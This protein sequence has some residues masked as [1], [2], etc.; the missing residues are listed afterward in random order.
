MSPMHVMTNSWSNEP[1]YKYLN[2]SKTSLHKSIE[3]V[4]WNGSSTNGSRVYILA[5][6][7][8]GADA[9]KYFVET[10]SAAV[11]GLMDSK[12]WNLKLENDRTELIQDLTDIF[13]Q[14]DNDYTLLKYDQFSEWFPSYNVMKKPDDDGCTLVLNIIKDGYL[15]NAN[16]GDSRTILGVKQEGETSIVFSS[17]DHN[18]TNPTKVL[19]IIQNGGNFVSQKGQFFNI[20]SDDVNQDFSQL[21]GARIY[22]SPSLL[23]IGIGLSHRRTLNLTGSMGDIHFK[24]EPPVLSSTPDVSIMELNPT[25]EYVMIAATD[26]VWDHLRTAPNSQKQNDVV[27]DLAFAILEGD[28]DDIITDSILP[29]SPETSIDSCER[30]DKAMLEDRLKYAADALVKRENADQSLELFY[31]RMLRY[32]DAT[33]QIIHMAP[34][35]WFLT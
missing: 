8:G 12:S 11:L 10:I 1:G 22:R 17:V 34:C 18:T 7:H 30:M 20:S 2:G 26:G 28:Y 25:L 15:I 6:G 3:D 33:A 24:L 19:E 4:A 9:A 21:F 31:E 32:D 14:A 5:D 29:P 13:I 23:S 16:V 27:K 35:D